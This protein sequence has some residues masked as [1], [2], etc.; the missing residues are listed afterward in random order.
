M[1]FKEIRIKKN[2]YINLVGASTFGVLLIHANSDVMRIWLWKDV[3]RTID[4]YYCQNF[5][6]Y[7]LTTCILVFLICSLL[8]IFR[9][10][11]VEKPV[12]RRFDKW[13]NKNK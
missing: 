9:I 11:I 4:N 12:L 1:F 5:I 2:K 3:T 13:I 8:D 10:K 7:H 6:S